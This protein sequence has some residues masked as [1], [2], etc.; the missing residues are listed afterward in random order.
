[1]NEF[2]T[3]F[4]LTANLVLSGFLIFL[5]VGPFI[6][7]FPGIGEN[8]VPMRFKLLIAFMFTIILTPVLAPYLNPFIEKGFS[9]PLLALSETTIGVVLGIGTRLFLLALQTTGSIAAQATSLAMIL[10]NSGITPMPAIGHLLV[11]GGLALAMILGLHVK[12]AETMVITYDVFPLSEFPSAPDV[13]MWGID[14][15]SAAFALA[16]N[17][18]APFLIV[19][20]LYNVTLGVINKAMPQMM[21][22][23]V[24]APVITGTGLAL[25]FLL[26]PKIL[27]LWTE[28]LDG[29][30]ANPFGAM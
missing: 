28:A 25:L 21:V 15:V 23:F 6:M 13:A 24:G 19:S 10:G 14:Q 20:M 12:L 22:V 16:F 4:G 17:L 11:I 1:M 9:F 26:A 30:L 29:F 27:A 3:I 2:S 5:R 18:A 7:L 8:T